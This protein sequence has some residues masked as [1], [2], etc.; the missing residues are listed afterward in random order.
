MAE[1]IQAA[2]SQLQR[3]GMPRTQRSKREELEEIVITDEA[4]VQLLCSVTDPAALHLERP[5]QYD[6]RGDQRSVCIATQTTR[7][8]RISHYFSSPSGPCSVEASPLRPGSKSSCIICVWVVQG[9]YSDVTNFRQQHLQDRVSM[10]TDFHFLPQADAGI[11]THTAASAVQRLAVSSRCC[12]AMLLLR[13]ANLR[14][15]CSMPG[16]PDAAAS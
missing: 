13:P 11:T 4:V 2:K 7:R 15:P 16:K 9:K 14:C 1:L 8:L 5:S 6:V 3:E 12:A 10:Q